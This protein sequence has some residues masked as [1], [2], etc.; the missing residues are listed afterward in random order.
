MKIINKFIAILL[1]LLVFG[2]GKPALAQR[3]SNREQPNIVFMMVDNL[4]WGEIG[5]YGGGILRGAATPR[6]DTFASEGMKLLNFNVEPQ[7]T[8]SRSALMTGRHPIRSGTTKVVWGLPYGL[9]GWEQ[10]WPELLSDAGYSTGMFGKWHLGD[11]K[12][13]FPTDQGFDEWYGI[14]NTT[15]ESQYS[16]QIAFDAK[17]VEPPQI[18]EAIRNQSPKALKDYTVATRRLIDT[19]ITDRAIDFMERQV[20]DRKPFF[21]YI[22]FTQPH[23]PSLPHPEFAGQTGNGDWADML[24]EMDYHAGEVLDAIERLGIRDNTIVVWCSDNGPEEAPSY[25]GTSGYWRGHYFTTLEGSLRVPFLIRWPGKI[26][27]GSSSNEIVHITDIMPTFAS[28]AGYQV[29][30]DRQ[31]DGLNQM[32][33]F[34]GQVDNSPRE[35]F[36]AYNGD[37][38]Q[39]YKWRNFKVEFVEQNSMFDKPARHNFPRVYDL[40]RDPKEEYGIYGGID[41]GT[42]SLTWVLPAVSQQ[43]IKFQK[44]LTEEPP[45]PLGTPE[46]Y[47]PRHK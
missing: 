10:T 19:E 8:P 40:L 28:V 46:P 36:P 9:V 2:F 7:C 4:G 44:T 1:A 17:V 11:T 31:I 13:R 16:G 35:G 30:Q 41:N 24:A 21:A 20:R 3:N 43:I 15:D 47:T 12:G 14:A 5:A 18:Q 29:P 26:Q 32:P 38:M 23:L 42:E 39:A 37:T 22:P 34:T 25:F 27:P 6:L 33:F 45:I